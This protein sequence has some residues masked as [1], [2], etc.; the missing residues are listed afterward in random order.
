MAGQLPM[1]QQAQ[2]YTSQLLLGP[3]WEG[4][5]PLPGHRAPLPLGSLNTVTTQGRPG[6]ALSPSRA[7]GASSLSLPRFTPDR[8]KL[9]ADTWHLSKL[10]PYPLGAA[11]PHRICSCVLLSYFWQRAHPGLE[12]LC[13]GM[14]RGPNFTLGAARGQM[15]CGTIPGSPQ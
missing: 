15:A 9:S 11:H 14:G 2:P 5:G 7:L 4:G 13:P 12:N 1:L 6:P 8:E 10:V 3:E